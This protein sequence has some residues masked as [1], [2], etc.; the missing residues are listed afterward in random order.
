MNGRTGSTDDAA[1]VLEMAAGSEAALETLYDRYATSIFAA[2][3]RLTSDRGTAE[4]VVQETFLALWNRAE[5]FDPTAGSLAAWLH[6][7]ARNRTI[8]RLRAAGRRPSLVALS[9]A[10]GPEEDATQALERL[11]SDGSIVGGATPGPSPEQAYEAVGL[12]EAISLAL[13]TMPEAERTVIQM[14]YQEELSQSE[15][16][17]RLGWP[18]GTVKTRT[19]RALLRLREGLGAEFGPGAE[20]AV[21]PV[22][23]G[24]DR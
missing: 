15:I 14:A 7:I 20:L 24:E 21:M 5:T 8:D 22:P 12:Q 1:V 16:A 3:Y 18:L 19:R 13:S 6:A 17:A 23:V 9:S 2:A 4:E 11:V 10:A